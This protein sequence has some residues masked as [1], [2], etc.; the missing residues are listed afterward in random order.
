M[1]LLDDATLPV[2]E[3]PAPALRAAEPRR[4]DRSKTAEAAPITGSPHQDLRPPATGR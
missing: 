3:R 2:V 1:N 4:P